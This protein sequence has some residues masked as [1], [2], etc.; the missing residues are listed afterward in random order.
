MLLK[1][2]C[3]QAIN[4][5]KITR[6]DY[7]KI[8]NLINPTSVFNFSKEDCKWI[9]DHNNNSQFHTY[10][11]NHENQLILIVVPLDKEGK[12]VEL[13]SYL[14]SPLSALKKE[15]T[16]IETDVVTTTKTT[17][18]SEQLEITKHQE[19]KDLPTHNEPT[20]TEK[21]SVNDI[22]QWKNESLDWFYYE[23]NNSEGA[24]IVRVFTVPF[25]D[26]TTEIV[27]H[28]S[29]VALFGFKLLYY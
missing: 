17:V 11:G 19:E 9:S 28:D 27:E 7:S 15:L 10:I 16:L 2:D 24:R 5:W 29:A 22:Q 25:A 13:L 20:I 26:L 23:S 21:A 1:N 4:N 14:T 6:A 8:E 3:I 18:L 12:E